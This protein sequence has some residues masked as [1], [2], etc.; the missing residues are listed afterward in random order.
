MDDDLKVYEIKASQSLGYDYALKF[1][2]TNSPNPRLAEEYWDNPAF[3][4]ASI[5]CHLGSEQE[6]TGM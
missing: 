1:C 3:L 2:K 6:G 4:D 5:P